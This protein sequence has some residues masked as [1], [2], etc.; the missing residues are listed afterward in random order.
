MPPVL[1]CARGRQGLCLGAL[2]PH[3]T[4]P[5]ATPRGCLPRPTLPR[6]G[7][8]YPVAGTCPSQTEQAPT[9]RYG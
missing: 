9:P 4:Y 5:G 7:R 6:R 2:C 3:P 1:P 8:A